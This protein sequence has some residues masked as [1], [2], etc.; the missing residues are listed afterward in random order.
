MDNARTLP[1]PTDLERNGKPLF[2]EVLVATRGDGRFELLRSPGMVLGLARGDVFTL[3]GE[4]L[5]GFRVDEHS[6]NVAIQIY[7]ESAIAEAVE[8]LD[9]AL[10]KFS[11]T[12]DGR[13]DHALVFTVALDVGL[14]LVTGEMERFAMTFPGSEWQYGNLYDAE[15]EPL[16]WWRH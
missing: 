6:G 12:L 8:H 1:L 7:C 13:T 16:S 14:E 4:E 15:G 9:R 3:L 2:E 5:P 10:H 11:A